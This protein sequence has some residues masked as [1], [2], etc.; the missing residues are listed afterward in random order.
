[1]TPDQ[2]INSVT[3]DLKKL[4]LSKLK[5]YKT[6]GAT[7]GAA[8]GAGIG[9]TTGL[10]KTINKHRKGELDELDNLGKVKEYLKTIGTHGGIGLGAGALIGTGAGEA[11]RRWSIKD[12]IQGFKKTLT[13]DVDP[14]HILAAGNWMKA[15]A[16]YELPK[17]NLIHGVKE[18]IKK[19]LSKKSAENTTIMNTQEQ[20]YINGFVKKASEYGLNQQDAYTMFKQA[21]PTIN[22]PGLKG[23]RRGMAGAGAL[24]G[25]VHGSAIGAGVGALKGLISPNEEIDPETGKT[26]QSGRLSSML[27]NAGKYGLIGGG[28]GAGVG[29][30]I[31]TG[32][33]HSASKF[34]NRNATPGGT[35][36]HVPF[37]NFFNRSTVQD[38]RSEAKDYLKE[39]IANYRNKAPVPPPTA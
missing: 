6:V 19:M 17:K 14:A 5:G 15:E 11:G 9:G 2:Q 22:F 36:V 13:E 34:I 27:S 25:G 10:I 28:V 29:A 18:E 31:G 35:P 24:S 7:A 30:G 3:A 23:Y 32:M 37:K 12:P 8:L 21:S 33:G 38:F 39:L 1:M 20:A 4:M 26:V 16:D